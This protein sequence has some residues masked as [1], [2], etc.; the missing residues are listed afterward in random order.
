M[1]KRSTHPATFV[2]ERYFAASPAEVFAAWADPK[3]KAGWFLGSDELEESD[4]RLDF[5]IGGQESVRGGPPGGPVHVYN[6]VYRDIVPNE[7]IVYTYDMHLDKWRISVSLATV[8]LKLAKSGTRMIFTEQPILDGMDTVRPRARGTT[9]DLLDNL[10]VALRREPVTAWYPKFARAH[11]GASTASGPL[12]ERARGTKVLEF[13]ARRKEMAAKSNLAT[14]DEPLVVE[15]T[16]DAPVALV[17]KAL[18]DKD[19]VKQW[20]FDMPKFAPR[21][22]CEFEFV[23][24]DPKGVKYLH[25]G[26]VTAVVSEKKLAYT[27]RYEGHPGDSLVTFE[28]FPEGKRTKVKVTTTKAWKPSRSFPR[29]QERIS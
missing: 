21:V 7:R 2:I 17:W 26:K 13:S 14:K 24:G 5:R 11:W 9:R 4:H 16:F 23:G 15:R 22:G 29:S 20:S 6:A 28:L 19:D 1:R 8:E 3:V 25:R 18:T 27:W 12:F 10:D